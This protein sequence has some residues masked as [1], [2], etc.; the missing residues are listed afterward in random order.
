MDWLAK[1]LQSK[2]VR[3]VCLMKRAHRALKRRTQHKYLKL[4]ECVQAIC[5]F[6]KRK[7]TEFVY[8][9]AKGDVEAAALVL[10][11]LVEIDSQTTT[12]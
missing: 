12:P 2:H 6:Q 4:C 3:W 5:D 9:S 8:H 11:F 10:K 7:G 1:K